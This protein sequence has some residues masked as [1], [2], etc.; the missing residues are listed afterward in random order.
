MPQLC[1]LKVKGHIIKTNNMIKIELTWIN[2]YTVSSEMTTAQ[3][4]N[5]KHWRISKYP[6][7]QIFTSTA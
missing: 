4:V 3:E 6:S 1:S 7:T 2:S 5:L